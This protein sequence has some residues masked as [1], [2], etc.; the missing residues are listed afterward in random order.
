[1]KLSV[2]I[3]CYNESESL[4]DLTNSI[5]KF[6]SDEIE[7]ILV[8]NGST[9]D[10]LIEFEKLCLHK[11]LSE[12]NLLKVMKQ[13]NF[14]IA[15]ASTICYEL[16]CVKMPILSGYFVDNQELIYKGFSRENAIFKGGDFNGFSCK[17]FSTLIEEI[18]AI[19]NYEPYLTNQSRLFDSQI[20][21]RF[22]KLI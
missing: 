21:S 3:P 16:C 1:M 2:V 5:D 9:D 20:K 22:L 4:R 8:N 15:P 17:D 19:E 10:T 14:A 13:C 12:A 18:L 11:N 7:F 6:I